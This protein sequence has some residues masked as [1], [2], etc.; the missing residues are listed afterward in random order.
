MYRIAICD[1][2]PSVARE[3]E[4]MLHG[5]LEE[6]GLRRDQ[7]FSITRFSTAEA[8]LTALREHTG[9]FHLLLLDIKLA[10]GS[11]LELAGRLREARITCSIIYITAYTEFMPDSFATRPLDYLVKPVDREKLAKAVDW[12]LRNNFCPERI[13]LPVSGGFRKAA[14]KDILYAEAVN[15]KS[16]VY[17]DGGEAVPV[18]LTF[19]DLLARLP[20][21]A[22][23]RCHH[24]FAVNLDHVRERTAHGLLLDNGMELPVSR[25]YRQ[26]TARRFAGFLR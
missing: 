7:D 13:T 24:S 9:A 8:L 17:L 5:I 3:N 12:D 19:R 23:C 25:T 11:G 22:F 15:H 4:S 2:E 10:Q 14:L 6:R 26:E 1:N 16:A 20:G 21:D 18:R